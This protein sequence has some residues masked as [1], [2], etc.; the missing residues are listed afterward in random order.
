MF[1][2]SSS[3][4]LSDHEAKELYDAVSV[5]LFN[6]DFYIASSD[7]PI[8]FCSSV[9]RLEFASMLGD[10]QDDETEED[11]F[12]TVDNVASHKKMAIENIEGA[13]CEKVQLMPNNPSIDWHGQFPI[14]IFIRQLE[15]EMQKILSQQSYIN[16]H[17][18][19]VTTDVEID[20]QYD[21]NEV[22]DIVLNLSIQAT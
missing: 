21:N 1:H 19:I 22:A 7:I 6:R 20:G 18:M 3:R 13:Q 5:S 12:L 4:D 14:E 8:Q 9:N 2:I 15:D 17:N 10:I 16:D 11:S